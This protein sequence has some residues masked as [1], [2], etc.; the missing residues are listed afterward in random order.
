MHTQVI[1][2]GAGPVGLTLAA[3]LARYGVQ[4]RIID[5]AGG[6]TDRSKALVVWSRTL[7][8][9]ERGG[10]AA[11]FLQAGVKLPGVNIFSRGHRIA[12]VDLAGIQSA[13][14]YAL[15]LEQSRTERLL[16][17][18]LHALGI[19]VE[20]RMEAAAL[21]DEGG[22]VSLTLRRPDSSSE[23]ATADWL[24]GC[25]GAH[26]FVR[27]SLGIPFD[28]ATLPSDWVLA[29]VRLTGMPTPENQP[30]T[31]WHH[32]G[33]LAV[34]PIRQGHYRVIADLG[35]SQ[36]E[37]PPDPT[38][39]QVQQIV[40]QRGPGGIGVSEPAWLSGFRINERKVA[41]Y[42]R[43]RCFLVGDAAHVHSPAGG[44]GMNTGMQDAF[45]LAW[46]L[47]LVCRG[48]APAESL[49]ASYSV[50]R[51]AVG[52]QVLANAG[53]LTQLATL[54]N[55]LAM[56]VRNAFGS[57]LFGLSPV[58]EAVAQ[59]FSEIT[60]GY[61]SSPLTGRHEHGLRP[62]PGERMPPQA[63]Q[64][65]FGAGDVPRF[66]LM[67]GPTA[68][69]Q[70]LLEKFGDVLEPALRPPPQ[71]SACWLVRPDGYVACASTD[72]GRIAHYLEA[73]LHR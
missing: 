30:A 68:A 3:E 31:W 12:F 56:A 69:T 51:S 10:C 23:P 15:M 36:G 32:Q 61:P 19:K 66:S 53:R 21:R 5:K 28:G 73:L 20:R 63:G 39:E 1:V 57:L 14:N 48:T 55:P 42:R 16:E 27:H 22:G 7:E 35:P 2:V 49:L 60:I 37:R 70:S 54:R 17:A 52:D 65:P 38:L 58:N 71:A 45:N 33:A 50:E 72:P 64:T 29:D 8:L 44:Q 6:P 40:D 43:G 59:N 13:Y 26:S 9:L 62:A 67:A 34:F 41:D 25:D 4:V 47:A 24:L 46:K 18:H 11:Q